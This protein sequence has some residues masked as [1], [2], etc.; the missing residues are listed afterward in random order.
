MSDLTGCQSQGTARDRHFTQVEG[1]ART[2]CASSN[3]DTANLGW[4]EPFEV[5]GPGTFCKKGSG[6]AC[7]SFCQQAYPFFAG[8]LIFDDLIHVDK[9]C[10]F[11][12]T[13]LILADN[14]LERQR[15]TVN[16]A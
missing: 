12:T 1:A 6:A 4:A 2:S 3:H 15:G 16:F 5:R 9:S 10:I 11:Y 8:R 13:R 7:G 14:R